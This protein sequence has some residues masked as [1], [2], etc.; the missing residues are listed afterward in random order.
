MTTLAEESRNP[1]TSVLI[2]DRINTLKAHR[3][4]VFTAFKSNGIRVVLLWEMSTS[5]AV[6][7]IKQRKYGH[8]TIGPNAN[9]QMIVGRTAKEFETLSNDEIE[10]YSI[11]KVVVIRDPMSLTRQEIVKMVLMEL[12]EIP[13]LV[14]LE[15]N[16]ITDDDI[17]KAVSKT[18]T[19]EERISQENESASTK[20]G[21]PSTTSIVKE[22]RFEI[23][24]PKHIE[25]L[26]RISR[27]FGNDEMGNK[28]E[29]HVTLLY[30]NRKLAKA[31]NEEDGT[32]TG[33]SKLPFGR[34]LT[35]V[36][37]A[38]A[39][40][41]TV[42]M[43]DIPVAIEY[44]AWNDRVMAAKVTIMDSQIGYFDVCPHI[45]L[46]KIPRAEFRESNT[47]ISRCEDIRSHNLPQGTDGIYWSNLK[48]G[49]AIVGRLKFTNHG[50]K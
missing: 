27:E 30:I 25:A 45:S 47:L 17:D 38:L 18:T 46:A 29:F 43:K 26:M 41:R 19:R 1:T 40:Y 33:E 12:S 4:D 10:K 34:N 6:A 21:K 24:F 48:E 35:D 8:R 7:R 13:D 20:K 32:S 49:F 44:V 16:R 31:I 39:I 37:K 3:E 28:T 22:G 5:D 23:S 11:R 2:A 9:V 50:S 14:Y 36:R 15:L 42:S